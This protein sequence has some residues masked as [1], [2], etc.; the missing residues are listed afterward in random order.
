MTENPLYAINSD[1]LYSKS[2]DCIKRA[3]HRKGTED[4][5]KSADLDR[6]LF[7]ER[8]FVNHTEYQLWASI[9]LELLGKA[10]LAKHHPCLVVDPR[11]LDS[12][13]A[14]AGIDSKADGTS[15][16]MGEVRTLSAR[17]VYKRLKSIIPEYDD[18]AYDLCIT[19]AENRNAELHSAASPFS[20]MEPDWEERYWRACEIILRYI[21]RTFVQ[22]FG[23]TNAEEALRMIEEAKDTRSRK[24]EEVA[25]KVRGAKQDFDKL[26]DT[27][28]AEISIKIK[29][30]DLRTVLKDF[31][32]TYEMAWE[33]S[34]PSCESRS[35]MAGNETVSSFM[36][37]TVVVDGEFRRVKNFG[38]TF[39]PS[40]FI[41]AA[42]GLR[43]AD[44]DEIR[45]AR[46]FETHQE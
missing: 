37:T 41:C 32:K 24:Q 13:L 6:A 20:R 9:A 43:L 3:L 18:D 27:E 7:S 33:V 36:E 14:A 17:E 38:R 11:R 39:A 23:D 46:M 34:C 29:N 16:K 45:S 1:L 31:S 15:I 12:M 2:S 19:T 4:S 30:M 40:E 44:S 42:C 28:R 35:F 10:A 5:S 26:G 21:E 8:P 22:W 25:I